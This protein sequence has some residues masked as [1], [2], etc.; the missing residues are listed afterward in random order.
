M[1]II[2]KYSNNE[3]SKNKILNYSTYNSIKKNKI[4]QIKLY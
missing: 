1:D 4:L 2:P 3:L